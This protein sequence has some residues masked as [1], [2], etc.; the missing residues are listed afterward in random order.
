MKEHLILG[1]KTF[2]LPLLAIIFCWMFYSAVTAKPVKD[3]LS[4]TI[5][6]IKK[7]RD[8]VVSKTSLAQ[9]IADCKRQ[10]DCDRLGDKLRLEEEA[11]AKNVVAAK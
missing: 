3:N 8:K 2:L 5:V 9:Q 1:F 4:G 7:E 6:Q 11:K 10:E